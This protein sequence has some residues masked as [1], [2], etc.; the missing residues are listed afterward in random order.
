MNRYRRT[1]AGLL[2]LA[3]IGFLL[4]SSSY[5][6]HTSG[7][8]CLGE[9]CP[10]C[11]TVALAKALQKS[12]GY[13]GSLPAIPFALLLARTELVESEESKQRIPHTLVGWKVRLDC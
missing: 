9:S 1:G 3:L 4:L 5:I 8:P 10:V 13:L 2:C 6:L 7:H 11:K 12:L